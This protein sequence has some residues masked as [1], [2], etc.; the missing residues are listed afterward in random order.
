MK[1]RRFNQTTTECSISQLYTQLQIEFD[2]PKNPEPDTM[3]FTLKYHKKVFR[4]PQNIND[5]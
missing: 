1:I 3:M 2:Q 4:L 5:E